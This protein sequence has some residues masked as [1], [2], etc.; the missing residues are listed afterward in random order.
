MSE[1]ICYTFNE[2]Q[3]K[4]PEILKSYLDEYVDNTDL[5][6]W[7]K[8]NELYKECLDNVTLKPAS[9]GFDKIPKLEPLSVSIE[10]I[11]Y[12]LIGW[13]T[14][15]EY[16]AGNGFP[17]YSLLNED[18]NMHDNFHKSFS[19][20]LEF[21]EKQIFETVQK[22]EQLNNFQNITTKLDWQGTAL[23]FTELFKS[24]ILSNKLN[25]ELSQTEIFNRLK[26]FFNINDFK[27]TD[28]LRDIRKRIN[29]P[30]P[31]LNILETSLNNWIK[32][33]D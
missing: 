23:E 21:I 1:I 20:I 7:N 24:L 33:K 27:E 5:L 10:E 32:E 8:Q 12:K 16:V 28:K 2:Y 3:N 30:T 4:Y 25:P 15:K 9:K 6:F 19:R 29:T 26:F 31:F 13:M 11:H 17:Q 22:P 14:G 18:K